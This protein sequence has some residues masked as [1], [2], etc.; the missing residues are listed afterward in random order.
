MYSISAPTKQLRT[1][2]ANILKKYQRQTW[3][4]LSQPF[5]N[6]TKSDLWHKQSCIK[7]ISNIALI[8]VKQLDSD[9]KNLRVCQ[10]S[11]Q[12]P[13]AGQWQPSWAQGLASQ[14]PE[15]KLKPKPRSLHSNKRA[16]QPKPCE[17]KLVGMGQSRTSS[18]CVDVPTEKLELFW[19]QIQ[20]DYSEDPQE[21]FPIQC[22][23]LNRNGYI[24]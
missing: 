1:Y 17:P 14:G 6:K 3:F 10:H 21:S 9:A 15:P 4:L 16:L 13:V 23:L 18:R 12:T 20:E 11:D 22:L 7:G 19:K 2:I 24:T 8:S 5:L